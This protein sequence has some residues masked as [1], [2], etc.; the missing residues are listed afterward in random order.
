MAVRKGWHEAE[1]PVS[2]PAPLTVR[3]ERLPVPT[4][5]EI[6]TSRME[7]VANVAD[8]TAAKVLVEHLF[9]RDTSKIAG[10][11][12]AVGYQLANGLT[13]GD[14]VDVYHFDND[15][16]SF[17]IADISGKGTEAAVHAAMVK[18]GMRAYASQGLSPE[19][20]LRALDRLYLENTA[21]EK[22][23]SFASVFF[24]L[25]DSS[26]RIMQYASGGHEPVAIIV[27]GQ[28]ARAIVPT[29][30]LIGV[31]D[32]QHHLFKQGFVE[33]P[34]GTVFVAT[35]DGIT[36][37]RSPDRAFFGMEAFI[38]VIEEKAAAPV[39]EIVQT[40]IDRVRAFSNDNLRD[41]IAIVVAR[42]L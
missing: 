20:V 25:V 37:A 18:Y 14:I 1:D 15:A 39:D 22:I 36:E 32:D 38:D 6:A 42:F 13:G 16:A 2:A 33:L 12:Y 5:G 9:A 24:G 11:E 27:P 35:T 17:C 26:R 41:D 30:P 3:P 4:D 8:W 34:P 10:I 28:R 31:F 23:E 40:L 7:G 29:A 19:R 21:F